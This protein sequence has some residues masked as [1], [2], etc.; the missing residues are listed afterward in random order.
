MSIQAL[1]WAL[2][3]DQIENSGARFVLLV[4]ANYANEMGQCYP[5]RE[6]IAKKTSTSVRSV[7]NHINWLAEHGYLVWTNERNDSKQQTPNIYQ[8]KKPSANSAPREEKPSA[9]IAEAECKLRR[10]PSAESA[11]YTSVREPSEE[12]Y[13][14]RRGFPRTMTPVNPSSDLELQ[15]WLAPIA[16]AVGAK[17]VNGLP[18]RTKWETV[19][20]TAIQEQ[21]DLPTL[22]K[23]IESE[24]KR[25]GDDLQFFSPEICL[26]KLQMNGT[27]KTEKLP[28]LAEKL[29]DDQANRQNLR[30][31]PTTV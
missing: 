21:R 23:I 10:K 4:L 14:G 30:K 19:C 13:S 6:T 5:S 3:Q 27:M 9:N 29:A 26:Q 24:K 8:L 31:A 28:T 12:P 25:L 15:A 7:Q 1:N 11:Q 17:S 18:K 16:A 20:M 2:S 22:L